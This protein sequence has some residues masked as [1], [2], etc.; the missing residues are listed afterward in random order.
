M[1]FS[2]HSGSNGFMWMCRRK[3][4]HKVTLSNHA[5]SLFSKSTVPLCKWMEYIYRFSQGLQLRDR[6]HRRWCCPELN[7]IIQNECTAQKV[8]SWPFSTHLAEKKRLGLWHARG[9]RSSQTASPEDG[10]RPFQEHINAFN[11]K[12]HQKRLYCL[13]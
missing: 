9:Q 4:H 7:N 1:K 13:Q 6:F 8:Q 12:A 3:T 11:Q 10:A 2:M 5:G